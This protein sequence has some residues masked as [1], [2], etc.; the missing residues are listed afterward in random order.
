MTDV[1]ERATPRMSTAATDAHGYQHGHPVTSRSHA[2]ALLAL[3]AIHHLI[4]A[5]QPISTLSNHHYDSDDLSSL[6]QD[7]IQWLKLNG[8]QSASRH[9]DEASLPFPRIQQNEAAIYASKL[10]SR[11]NELPIEPKS[12]KNSNAPAA[13]APANDRPTS[14]AT[15]AVQKP[16]MPNSNVAHRSP[17]PPKLPG[18][19]AHG[20]TGPMSKVA[21]P[22]PED[23][24]NFTAA[25]EE[26]LNLE[27]SPQKPAK[28]VHL[29]PKDVQEE[30]L[31]EQEAEKRQKP[32]GDGGRRLSHLQTQGDLASSPSSTIGAYSAATPMLAQ[33][34]PDTSPGSESARVE[35]PQD[36]RPSPEEQRA[37]EEHDRQLEA[38]K[39]IARREALGD[40]NTPDDQLRWEE[41]EAAARNAE[42]SAA[43][44]D[45]NGPEPDAK[46]D[47]E[48][49]EAEIIAKEKQ[50]EQLA[51]QNAAAADASKSDVTMGEAPQLPTGSHESDGEN[52]TVTPR[53]KTSKP[54]AT[55][56]ETAD[57]AG[58]ST[59]TAPSAA[60][61]TPSTA[62]E[63]T[64]ATSVPEPKAHPTLRKRSTIEPISPKGT[65]REPHSPSLAFPTHASRPASRHFHSHT[66]TTA[67][68]TAISNLS[69][70]KGAADDPERD[71]LEPLFRIQAHDSGNIKT[72]PLPDLLRSSTKTLTTEDHFTSTHERGDYRMLR[73]I[74]QLQNANKW[75]FRQ[76]EKCR[77][78]PQPV[79]H[80]DN[81][82][83]EMKWMCKDF[84]AE[85][86]MKKS[87]CAWLA[88][89]CAD[90]VV[91][92]TEERKK[93]QVKVKPTTALPKLAE[94]DDGMPD[95]ESAGES[96]NEDDGM[97]TTPKSSGH[98]PSKLVV[99]PEL[100]DHVKE[101]EKAGSLRK[102][103][104]EVPEWK[105][106]DVDTAAPITKVSKFTQGKVFPKQPHPMRKRSRF[107]YEDEDE[108]QDQQGSK[109][110][111]EE[112]A[113]PAEDQEIALF[114]PENKSIRDRLHANN[115]FRPPS[116]FQMP[117]TP[118]YEFRNGS[119][120]VWED[121]QKLRKLAKDYSFNWSLIADEMNLPSS[122]KSGMERR[123]PWECFER[124]VDLEQL[125]AEM[126]KTVYF[127][128]WY[129]RLELSQQAVERRYQAQVAAMQQAQQN[130][131]NS[132]TPAP[133]MP[134]RR[135]TQPTR[136]EKRKSTRYL[137]VVDAMRKLARKREAASH[138]QS[139]SLRAAAQRKASQ[140]PEAT[141]QRV[142][143]KT[144][145]EWSKARFELD[146]QLAEQAR[147]RR[148][149]MIEAQQQRNAQMLRAQ[150]GIPNGPPAQQRPQNAQQPQGGQAP[151]QQMHAANGQMANQQRQAAP[152]AVRNGHL[153]V[154]HMN[155]QG[156]PQAHMR[157]DQGTAQTPDMQRMAHA[158]TQNPPV[159]YPR[160]QPYA[161][162]NGHAASPGVNGIT[163][164]QQLASNQALL[165]AFQAQHP[166]QQG[167]GQQAPQ[168]QPQ[169]P[170]QQHQQQHP[171]QQQTPQQ[172]PQ[173]QQQAHHQT[174]NGTPHAQPAQ[175]N[176][177][178]QMSASPSMPP[179]PTP[180]GNPQQL[181]SGHV[182]AVIQ[183]KNQ[184]RSRYPQMSEAELTNF[185][186]EQ[187]KHQSQSSGQMRQNAMNAAAGINTPQQPT[188]ANNAP[189][190][191]HNQTAYQTNGNVPNGTN[192]HAGSTDQ[193]A[194]GHAPQQQP[195]QQPQQLQQQAT[196]QQYTQQP[197]PQSPAQHNPNMNA[198]GVPANS[199]HNYAQLMRARQ[200]QQMRLQQQQQQP[201]Q[202]Q[203]PQA[204]GQAQNQSPST[205]HAQLSNG[206]SPRV[207]QASPHM[208]AASPHASPSMHMAQPNQGQGQSQGQGQARPPSRSQTPQQPPMQR[209]N[210][211]S[212]V[213]GAGMQSGGS[214][215]QSPVIAQG[216]P[217]PPSQQQT[218]AQQQTG[219]A[220]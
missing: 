62:V 160:G 128:T 36:L 198:A 101:L 12:T 211:S 74:Y 184:L 75:S 15:A 161:M 152:M 26:L 112:I 132:T 203:S 139:E 80:H 49:T 29:P 174:P 6:S 140:Q 9:F 163:T 16:V 82:M 145:Q 51:A 5:N 188:S 208:N 150:Q 91:A 41:R 4:E 127:K 121:D 59:T 95:L 17:E 13:G 120:W 65:R 206:G 22:E 34:S 119:Q 72:N 83:A 111:R 37:K 90:W 103:L 136:V 10:N 68:F 77:E 87:V 129:Q 137:W 18:D 54:A 168:Q 61:P 212:G 154:P 84:R 195:Q 50:A 138:K 124:W 147:Q 186:T 89:R 88:Q 35:V 165:A 182:P 45:A 153:A 32:N 53:T 30:R 73:R 134:V 202:Q 192:A 40:V 209:L 24:A 76:M 71:Y 149:K 146:L 190:Y 107:D 201:Q 115:A 158:N 217:R 43:T 55:T 148:Q 99:D 131:T 162:A 173:Q 219:V 11:T 172:H 214:G 70:L 85:R 213:P 199:Q 78:P 92:S 39:E 106:A 196:P 27:A 155:A 48:P 79:T 157:H 151:A 144:P 170:H 125:P 176:N 33:E 86:K 8:L 130:N 216:S 183:I 93:M 42:E 58:D 220:R 98:M 178:Q 69:T 171:Q 81:M 114:H 156:V 215:V 143:I 31:R 197:Q 23:E 175:V 66:S 177:G 60:E 118:F 133:H 207:A 123:T 38:Q 57:R 100:L 193:T 102:A 96:A 109:R 116:E 142:S 200:M 104:H 185:A 21:A 187:L 44:D 7:D 3:K 47:S 194:Q 94:Q 167:Q 122:F 2:S 126:R 205:P 64:E 105:P 20:I 169:Q 46:E 210:S 189:A 179:P 19:N 1:P 28:T 25:T 97:P 52:I 164:S 181:S 159:R 191:N 141:Q 108:L 166:Q 14:L 117:S 204:Q 113:M 56:Q 67:N 180:A 135:R 218:P 110:L 63:K